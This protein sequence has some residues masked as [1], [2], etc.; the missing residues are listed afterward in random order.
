MSQ[1]MK[2]TCIAQD[3][4]FPESPVW[5]QE[6][7]CLYLVEMEG[8]TVLVFKNGEKTLQFKV[9]PGGGPSG[10]CIDTDEYIWVCLYSARKIARYNL[11][12]EL[13]QTFQSF[14]GVPFR[15]ACDITADNM[16]GVYFT[17]SGDFEED[18][19]TGRAAGAV[20]YINPLR[21]L[22]QLD[23]D[24]SFPN[25]IALS[26]D[27]SV[28]YV[29]E[30]RRN[31]I[32]AYLLSDPGR[33]SRKSVLITL[34]DRS[35]LP[36]DSAFELGPDGLCVRSDGSLWAAHYG[37]GKVVQIAPSGERLGEVTLPHGR[38]PTSVCFG[39]DPNTLYVTESELGLLYSIEFDY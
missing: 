31:R 17:D 22:F 16:G 39:K 7:G 1:H 32:L 34:D 11:T 29:N 6:H 2:I 3:L 38:N 23:R 12:G 4:R 14:E 27:G 13:F 21:E 26:P 19:R 37:G 15:G 8:D 30:H 33:Y 20:Y 9:E 36:E 24:L 18:W 5:S 10:M 28:L 35:L 25:G